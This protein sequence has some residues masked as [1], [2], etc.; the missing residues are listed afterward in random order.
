MCVF[1]RILR[2]PVN[3]IVKKRELELKKNNDN[4]YAF[5]LLRLMGRVKLKWN[6]EKRAFDTR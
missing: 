5:K 3:K 4:L 2:M 6:N 1:S